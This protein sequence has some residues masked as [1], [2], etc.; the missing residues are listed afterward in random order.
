M[1]YFTRMAREA[2]LQLLSAYENIELA[3]KVLNE[4]CGSAKVDEETTYWVG[5]AL[6]EAL[7]NAI[8]H[9]NKLNPEKS[10]LVRI[11]LKGDDE[12]RIDVEDEGDGF[13]PTDLQD[14]TSPDNLLRSSGRG[15]FYMRQF[16]DQVSFRAGERGG[17]RIEL[18]KRLGARRAV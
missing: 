4:L 7:A 13:D 1:L 15:V 8:K 3:E 17:T 5:M 12:L 16:M 10:V 14:P 9:G 6:R 11:R 2:R 18:T